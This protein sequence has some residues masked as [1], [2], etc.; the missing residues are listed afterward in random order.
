[1]PLQDFRNQSATHRWPPSAA[2]AKRADRYDLLES[3]A[4]TQDSTETFQLSARNRER[5]QASSLEI[6]QHMVDGT[7]PGQSEKL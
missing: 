5:T 1:M 7:D 6:W 3:R 2:N 4:A